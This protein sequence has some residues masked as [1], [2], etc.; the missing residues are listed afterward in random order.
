MNNYSPS[1]DSFGPYSVGLGKDIE[2]VVCINLEERKD[3]L[4]HMLQLIE[5]N[6]LCVNFYHP[7]KNIENPRLG[8]AT[9]HYNMIKYAKDK[10]LK[11]ILILEDDVFFVSPASSMLPLPEKYDL[12]FFGGIPVQFFDNENNPTCYAQPN[13]W[14]RSSTWCAHAY[15]VNNSMYDEILDVGVPTEIP[16]DAVYVNYGQKKE[17]RL[18]W[19]MSIGQIPSMSDIDGREKWSA[20]TWN[21]LN[22]GKQI[23]L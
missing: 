15:I 17:C 9:S 11:N 21:D 5:D 20:D 7:S 6:K 10:G 14:A 8:C 23:C 13:T 2:E 22:N 1:Y 19:H 12:L 16:I 4:K 18:H 3:R